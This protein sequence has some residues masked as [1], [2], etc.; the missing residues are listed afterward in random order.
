MV[1]QLVKSWLA[2]SAGG[3]HRANALL[4]DHRGRRR[5]RQQDVGCEV[6]EGRV[7]LTIAMLGD[8]FS[9]LSHAGV[10]T[11][12]HIVPIQSLLPGAPTVSG[13][14]SAAWT[15]LDNDFTALETELQTLAAKSGLTISDLQSL[16]VDTQS[17]QQTGFRFNPVTLNPAI[18]DLA[19]AVATGS[20]KPVSE[21]EFAALFAGSRVSTA[22]IDKTFSDLA[23]SIKDSRVTVNDLTT[24]AALEATIRTDLSDLGGGD[25]L[26]LA[27]ALNLV[28]DSSVVVNVSPNVGAPAIG[29]S[30]PPF[31]VPTPITMPPVKV[32]PPGETEIL[33]SLSAA[34]VVTSPV[35][36]LDPALLQP[37][38]ATNVYAQLEADM[39]A[40][41]KELASLAAKSGVTVADLESLTVD[42]Q[43]A[44]QAGFH[45]DPQ[46]ANPVIAELAAAVASGGSTAQAKADFIALF[47]GSSVATTVINTMFAD[48]VK[49]IQDS[50]VTSTDL[51][52]VS[53]QE[54]AI[55][56]DLNHL[57][58]GSGNTGGSGNGSGSSGGSTSGSGSTGTT[59]DSGS[60]GTTSGAVHHQKVKHPRKRHPLKVQIKHHAA[61]HPLSAKAT[62][63]KHHR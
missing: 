5:A 19:L 15:K 43:A 31:V 46:T 63:R 44:A 34:G 16:T 24:V 29:V 59:S 8:L 39:Q 33:A 35:A 53:A 62:A 60:T 38:S 21:S 6:L 2:R 20:T 7:V 13:G 36:L 51:A 11:S 3:D 42:G 58:F 18:Y 10:V 45:F 12:P 50:K 37:V 47:A 56:T 61:R 30:L 52:T 17:I 26:D 48:T 14:S 40:L 9:S 23:I 28:Q 1:T 55:Q 32:F 49:A 4:K 25:V 41:Q 27:G 22:V 54:A 57:G